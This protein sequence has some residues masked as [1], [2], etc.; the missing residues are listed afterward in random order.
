MNFVIRLLVTAVALW[1][2]VALVPGIENH[3]GWF[4]LVLVALIFGLVNA[5]IRPI[6]LA[7]TCPLVLL[8]LG[9]FIFVLNALMLWLTGY[10]SDVI[11]LG[12]HVDGFIPALIGGLVVGVVSTVL[13]IFVGREK[14]SRG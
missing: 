4:H 13:N 14:K 8:T 9:L 10:L 11:G 5:V 7:L 2:A 1:A 3:A 6:L 12:F